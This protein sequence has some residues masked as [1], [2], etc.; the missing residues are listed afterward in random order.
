MV[1]EF[2]MQARQVLDAH[3]R[4]MTRQGWR[5]ETASDSRATV[6]RPVA[7]MSPVATLLLVLLTGPIG[8]G[9]WAARHSSGA[10]RQRR[11][12]T[13]APDHTVLVTAGAV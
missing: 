12:I 1:M 8:L 13:V 9:M 7:W 10:A 4:T 11:L 2:D 5:V 6:S 3:L